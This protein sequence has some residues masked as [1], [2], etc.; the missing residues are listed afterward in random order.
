MI[1]GPNLDRAPAAPAARAPFERPDLWL[2]LAIIA[3]ALALRL[4]Y[5]I[6][7][8]ASPFFD[9]PIMDSRNHDLW[10]RSI[11]GGE[12]FL[13]GHPYFRAPLY[14]WFL[15][16]T[17]RLFGDGYFMPR[18]LQAM[19]GALSCGLVFLIARRF[20][21]RWAG[22]AAGLVAAT[23]WLLLYFDAELLDV[24]LS[25]FLNLV[26]VYLLTRALDK[27][28]WRI[29]AASG[30]ALGMAALARPTI[31]LFGVVAIGWVLM[32]GW[33]D[34]S[35]ALR[36]AGA[37]ALACLV[38][39]LPV[40]IRNAAVGHD[41]VPIAS[42][43]GLNLYIGNHPASDGMTAELPG[44]MADWRGSYFDSITMAEKA[45]GRKLKPSEVSSYFTRESLRFAISQPGPW[46][47]LTLHK[48]RLFWNRVELADNQ[49]IRFF[50]VRYA[51][52][53]RLLPIGIGLIAPLGMLGFLLALREWRHS[54]PLWG[55][56]AACALAVIPF[57]VTTRF[58]LPVVPMLIVLSAGAGAWVVQQI[59]RRRWRP[60]LL[61]GAALAVLAAWVNTQPA[62]MD[63]QDAHAYEIIGMREMES[64]NTAEGI[65][66]FRLGLSA[67]P[68]FPASLHFRLGQALLE[69]NDL[70]G[71]Q[72]EFEAGL[73]QQARHPREFAIGTIG[74]AVL[75]ERR[76]DIDQATYFFRETL[77]VDPTNTEA[78]A[79][80]RRLE[81]GRH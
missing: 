76:G 7:Y 15:A 75:A 26:F 42:Q 52:I 60:I 21:G 79:R 50:A 73:T 31:L 34:R 47:G 35:T 81:E 28:S 27:G 25:V 9:H 37:L 68:R 14:P 80:L 36:Q 22:A 10:A 18:V 64:G 13:P 67:Q 66:N 5:A 72:R 55:Y 16:S 65:R 49:P 61:A 12:P 38:P 56:T 70:A 33:R 57:F 77:R 40:T 63:P 41:F 8:Q 30:L 71:A 6:Q 48:F 3:L 74:L 45:L 4:I 32:I 54:F 2:L 59:R 23:F 58:K 20:Y 17:Y 44:G 43:G 19:L 24:P 1:R 29:F 11:I 51:P 53:V 62:G 39:I 78:A 46:L 69:Q